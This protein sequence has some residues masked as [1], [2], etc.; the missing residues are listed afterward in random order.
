MLS[1][2]I[3]PMIHGYHMYRNQ[4]FSLLLRTEGTIFIDDPT[5]VA[6]YKGI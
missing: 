3:K 2:T 5:D 1:W 6:I 4:N